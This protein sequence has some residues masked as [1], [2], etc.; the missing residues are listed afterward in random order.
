M[1]RYARQHF[2]S[3][4]R[5]R[6]REQLLVPAAL[7]GAGIKLADQVDRESCMGIG[8]VHVHFEVGE[9]GR[10]HLHRHAGDRA[11]PGFVRRRPYQ[12]RVRPSAHQAVRVRP[13]RTPV[14]VVQ[15]TATAS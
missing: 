8:H 12:F 10:T 15:Y 11:Q 3:R 2:V 4:A 7:E 9:Q 6:H 14:S 5:L 13:D 1:L